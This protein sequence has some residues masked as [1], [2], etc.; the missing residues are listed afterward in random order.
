[1]FYDVLFCFLWHSWGFKYYPLMDVILLCSS[2]L[3][4]F[5]AQQ[6]LDF[7]IGLYSLAFDRENGKK[8]YKKG[9]LK[10]QMNSIYL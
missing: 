5:L 10:I 1:M 3:M 6:G 9:N 4:I 7:S 8:I 2:V